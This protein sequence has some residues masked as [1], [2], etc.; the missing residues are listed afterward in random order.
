MNPIIWNLK[1]CFKNICINRTS[2]I[3]KIHI[4]KNFREISAVM[5]SIMCSSDSMHTHGK[6]KAFNSLITRFQHQVPKLVLGPI[7]ISLGM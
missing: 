6:S 1:R 4:I 5:N 3:N 7:L 2:L